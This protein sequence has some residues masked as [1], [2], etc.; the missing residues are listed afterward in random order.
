M[1]SLVMDDGARAIRSD[2][3]V[4]SPDST[5]V[6]REGDDGHISG[7]AIKIL[8]VIKGKAGIF[9]ADSWGAEEGE[10]LTLLRCPPG[11]ST[12]E[13]DANAYRYWYPR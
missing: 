8:F 3:E 13:I 12:F 6:W 10:D 9:M 2:I 11:G 1:A 7:E 4:Q 5:E